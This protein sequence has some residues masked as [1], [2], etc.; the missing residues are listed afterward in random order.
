MTLLI[1]VFYYV[2]SSQGVEEW[3]YIY[4]VKLSWQQYTIKSSHVISHINTEPVSNISDCLHLHEL[5]RWVLCS[6]IP[7]YHGWSPEKNSLKLY[8]LSG[9]LSGPWCEEISC[10]IELHYSRQISDGCVPVYY[11]TTGCCPIDWR[12]RK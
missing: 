3:N 10:G 11:G 12:C 8:M 5:M 2:S 4:K 1:T 9:T 7:H 6:H